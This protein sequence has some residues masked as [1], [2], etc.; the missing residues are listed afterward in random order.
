[1]QLLGLAPP[2]EGGRVG[3]VAALHD[4]AHHVGAGRVDEQG[5]L[6]EVGV[7]GVG[8]RPRE[9]HPDEHDPL[10]EAALDERH[11]RVAT[12]VAATGRSG[13]SA[14][15]PVAST[16]TSST[17]SSTV[18]SP[19]FWVG[20]A[21]TI[22]GRVELDVEG[23]AGIVHADAG[24]DLALGVGGGRHRAG[25]GP[26]GQGL[27]HA[28]LPH[29]QGELAGAGPGPHELHVGPAGDRLLRAGPDAS[30]TVVVGL[31]RPEQHDVGIAHVDVLAPARRA[32]R[33]SA[34]SSAPSTAW[35]MSTRP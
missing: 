10:P 6:V 14:L 22:L 30:R 23:A 4:P 7:D 35:P 17:A 3:P 25:P 13:R 31:G 9:H 27:A 15:A 24:A 33:R 34:P 21:R 2:D 16:R 26:A 8:R 11:G 32:G 19:T 29:P 12:S 5:Q 18:T 1:M 20:P 28:A